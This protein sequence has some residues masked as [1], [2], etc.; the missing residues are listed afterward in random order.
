MTANCFPTSAVAQTASKP[1]ITI[2]VSPRE[3]FGCTQQSLESIYSNTRIPF[4]LVYVDAGSPKHVQKY[5]TQAATKYNFTLLRSDH[6]LT[7]NQ[8]R[9]LGLSQVTTDYIVFVPNDIHV[10]T[11]WLERLW[12]CAR[13]TD[14][15]AVC[16]LAGVGTS[17][18]EKKYLAGGEAR[19]V[20]N[21]QGEHI[22][23][24]LYEN[25]FFVNQSATA[26]NSQL[27]R[28]SC[29]FSELNCLLVKRDIFEQIG[30][31]DPRL[32][33]VQADMDVCFSINNLG[34]P[35]FC[36]PTAVVTH[37][38]Q[39]PEHWS[40]WA[41][42]MLRWSDAWELE[43]LMR[44]QQKWDLNLEDYLRQRYSQLGQ[45]RH[46]AFLYPL[47]RRLSK[48]NIAPWLE[49]TAIDL[50]RWFNQVLTDRHAQSSYEAVGNLVHAAT[51]SSQATQSK[52]ILPQEENRNIK[53]AVS[54][55]Y[56]LPR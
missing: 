19:I 42:F 45:Y 32:L 1:S 50:E 31:L 38:R 14:A 34:E 2:V 27:S 20:M 29:E 5:L 22:H 18:H 53:V 55:A 28:R 37:M 21:I 48:N 40:D 12:Q 36:E 26:K 10:S 9:N 4:N 52:A 8:A 3:Q 30:Y 43:S 46:Q 39:R 35:I 54:Q 56:S 15:A 11:D 16:P 23:R 24:C 47:L 6:F 51:A 13:E 17:L 25:R 7:P 49:Q 41:Y 44:F 33:G